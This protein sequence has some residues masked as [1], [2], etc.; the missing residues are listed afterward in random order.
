MKNKIKKRCLI[1][2]I[3]YT[4]AIILIFFALK[5]ALS[6]KIY[7]G[8]EFFYPFF[9]W[10]NNNKAFLVF[11]VLSIGY[12]AIILIYFKKTL[13]HMDEILNA[14]EEIYTKDD[15]PIFL[16]R[17][18][19][20]VNEYM[21]RIKFNLKENERIARESEKRKEDLIVYLAHDL[22]TPLTSILGYLNILKEEEDLSE[23]FRKKYLQICY[24]KALR[25]EE[26]INEFFDI[27]RYN[28]KDIVLE[29]APVDFSFMMEQIIYEFKPLLKEKNLN[30]NS[31]IEPEITLSID[32]N[33]IER[34]IDN[35]IRNA[36]NYSY[37]DS[38]IDIVVNKDEE[39]FVNISVT[40]KGPTI[41]AEK[42]DYIFE[43]FFRIDPSR[44]SKTGSAGLGLAIAKSIV[45]AHNGEIDA[46][47]ENEVTEMLVRIPV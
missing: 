7:Y 20:E 43:E 29:K 12:F 21:N 38:T 18:L 3:L 6:T 11:L 33:K 34:V 39:S 14:M 46:K 30:I 44:G 10:A 27:T 2:A 40:N 15:E 32:P 8:H 37:K 22:K 45:V 19:E 25:L 42:L 26:L 5:S 4:L 36:I 31:D 9:H 16:S 23:R 1:W 41:S 28:L 35:I 17:D 47:S 13:K 24:D